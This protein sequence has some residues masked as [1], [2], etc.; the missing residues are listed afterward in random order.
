MTLLLNKDVGDEMLSDLINALNSLQ[1][2]DYL[3][4]YLCTDG[5]SAIHSYAITDLIEE[6]KDRIELVAFGDIA[7]AG[8][9]IFFKARCSRRIVA[10]TYGMYHVTRMSISMDVDQRPL[11]EG[12][13]Q[14]V[15]WGK[16]FAKTQ[17]LAF[18]STLPFTQKEAAKF[19]QGKDVH[20]SYER[21][22]NFL[23]Y[24]SC[25]DHVEQVAEEAQEGQPGMPIETPT[26]SEE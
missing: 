2:D 26:P 13:R 12:D 20:F 23:N 7:S 6:N 17:A 14:V 8:F 21:L 10:G 3:T 24:Q 9:E 4:V 19:K 1:G 22:L 15:A 5:G 25:V 16:N 18:C 11:N